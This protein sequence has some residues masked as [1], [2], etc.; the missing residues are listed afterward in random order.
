VPGASRRRSSPAL[1][2]ARSDT[3]PLSPRGLIRHLDHGSDPS[4]LVQ[5]PR[6]DRPM[7]FGGSGLSRDNGL[8][9]LERI[10]R[11]CRAE[12]AD[13]QDV[14]QSSGFR[15]GDRGTPTTCLT[16]HQSARQLWPFAW[17]VDREPGR[18][19]LSSLESRRGVTLLSHSPRPGEH[20]DLTIRPEAGRDLVE[21]GPSH[22]RGPL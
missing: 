11:D 6:D 5:C 13:S 7:S 16:C 9:E 18:Q 8:R 19:G 4:E 17:S 10:D 3:H 15:D 14:R 21:P 1:H 12:G 2:G 20:R 22:H